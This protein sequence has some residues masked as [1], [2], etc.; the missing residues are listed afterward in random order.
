VHL[1]ADVVF[2]GRQERLFPYLEASLIVIELQI[3]GD[4]CS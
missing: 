4:E 3:V 1:A 2:Y